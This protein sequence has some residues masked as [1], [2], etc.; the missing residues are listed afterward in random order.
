MQFV[1]CENEDV[2]AELESIVNG[3]LSDHYEREVHSIDDYRNFGLGY[4]EVNK[5]NTVDKWDF[6]LEEYD[7]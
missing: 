3:N 7:T 1:N 5:I 6:S 2:L 4:C